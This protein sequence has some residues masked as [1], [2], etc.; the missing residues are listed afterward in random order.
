MADLYA[1]VD[2][3]VGLP[4][5]TVVPWTQIEA[6]ADRAWGHRRNPAALERDTGDVEAFTAGLADRVAVAR[7]QAASN[8]SG[9]PWEAALD[10]LG[11]GW[12]TTTFDETNRPC[13]MDVMACVSG[14][15]PFI[16]H[17]SADTRDDPQLTDWIRTGVAYHE[18]AH[19][20]QFTNPEP[21]ASAVTAFGGDV[22]TMADCYALTV[23][24]GW[25]LEHEVPIDEYSYWE[26]S[27]GYGYTCNDEQ[28]QVIRDWVDGLGVQLR[29]VG[30]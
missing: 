17:V 6:F 27:V 29:P 30:A 10:D 26:V 2:P 25:S 5:A 21:T 11:R 9:S 28:K 13:N 20:L 3:L 12:V 15:A 1:T 14:A 23:L 4:Y 16:V 22:E 7:T 19:V 8:A 24:D 18:Y